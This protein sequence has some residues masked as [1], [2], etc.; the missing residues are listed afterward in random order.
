[1]STNGIATGALAPAEGVHQ[2]LEYKTERHLRAVESVAA[3]AVAAEY[4]PDYFNSL[5]G[6]DQIPCGD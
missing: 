4:V 2:N 3:I 1:M 5:A 6:G